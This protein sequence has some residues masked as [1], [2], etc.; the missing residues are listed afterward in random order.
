[1]TA[2]LIQPPLDVVSNMLP[3]LSITDMCVVS[4]GMPALARRS[5]IGVSSVERSASALATQNGHGPLTF[6]SNAIGSPAMNCVEARVMSMVAA[7]CFAYSFDS[8][9]SAG[10]F[11]KSGSA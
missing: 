3:S 5:G 7:R 4:L 10:I 9:P 6:E 1:M 2:P 8:R 11:T